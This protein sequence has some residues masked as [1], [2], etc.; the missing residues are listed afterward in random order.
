MNVIL[1]AENL[2]NRANQIILGDSMIKHTNGWEIAK[3]LK[4]ECKVYG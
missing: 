4:P 3:K 1:S 2:Q